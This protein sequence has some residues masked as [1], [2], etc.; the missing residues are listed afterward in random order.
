VP[1]L[2]PATGLVGILLTLVTFLRV[3]T[4]DQAQRAERALLRRL[5][6]TDQLARQLQEAARLL[7]ESANPR[8]AVVAEDLT[9]LVGRMEGVTR[10]LE[11]HDISRAADRE[12]VPLVRRGYFT[13]DFLREVVEEARTVLDFLIFRN[14]QFTD[15]G[16]L[17]AMERAAERGVRIRIL[18]LSSRAPLSVIELATLVL[19]RPTVTDASMLQHQLAESE[20]RIA[21]I[22]SNDWTRFARERFEYRGYDIAP[23]L[24]FVRVDMLIR[25]GFIGTLAQAQPRHLDE[26]PYVELPTRSTA[27]EVL[28]KHYEELWARS[29]ARRL[30]TR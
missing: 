8:A 23:S 12:P 16:L 20:L 2:G 28:L 9:G 1:Y 7:R 14:L 5:Y 22:V 11:A 4:V 17:Q 26:R 18:A 10:A 3:R 21:Q 6:G 13:P 25:G 24:H 30:T 19:P 27:G 29:Q 15:V